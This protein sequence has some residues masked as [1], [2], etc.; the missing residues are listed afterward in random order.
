MKKNFWKS[1]LIT[2]G[3]ALCV[4]PGSE[5]MLYTYSTEQNFF[6]AIQ[7]SGT[8]TFNDN[9]KVSTPTLQFESLSVTATLSNLGSGTSFNTGEQN[10]RYGF[11]DFGSNNSRMKYLDATT[12]FTLTFN[13]KISALGFY[14]TDLGDFDGDFVLK[15]YTDDTSTATF[16]TLNVTKPSAS[17][18][19][20]YYGFSDP[21][22]S[23]K[24]IEF[25]NSRGGW[26]DVGFENMTVGTPVPLPPSV[27]MLGSGLLGL[28]G[29]LKLRKRAS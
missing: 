11:S 16:N 27:L 15:L 4:A 10:G 19:L 21:T 12:S 13:D 20:I 22:K 23:Y 9:N 25:T 1:A 24:K 6:A 18:Q 3:L 14:I 2:M 5:A 26:D 29:L 17:T 8:E 7:N 28:M